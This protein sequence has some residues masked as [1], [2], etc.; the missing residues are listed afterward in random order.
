[1][2]SK[3][4]IVHKRT[5]LFDNANYLIGRGT[6]GRKDVCNAL[7]YYRVPEPPAPPPISGLNEAIEKMKRQEMANRAARAAEAPK[8]NVIKR[9]PKITKQ[10]E[11]HSLTAAITKML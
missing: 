3:D 6:F 7:G 2:G 8:L 5:T 10:G 11:L 9:I 1:M 4:G